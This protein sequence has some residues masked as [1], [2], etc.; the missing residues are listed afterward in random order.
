MST[1]T[2]KTTIYLGGMPTEP[3]VKILMEKFGEVAPGEVIDYQAIESAISVSYRS[4]RF[5]TV[6]KAFRARMLREKNVELKPLTGVGLQRLQEA[7]RVSVGVMG[8]AKGARAIGRSGRRLMRVE[9]AR[10]SE[11]DLKRRDHAIRLADATVG[12]LRDG[13]KQIAASAL[14]PAAS[15]PRRTE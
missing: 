8:V 13:L 14:Q 9:A 3:E 2:A 7:E 12:T 10:L 15:L 4:K 5:V 11:I 6:T 1:E